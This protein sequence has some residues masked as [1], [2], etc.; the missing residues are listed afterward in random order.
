MFPRSL[1]EIVN[2]LMQEVFIS[3][4]GENCSQNYKA[5]Q[6]WF[7][8]RPDCRADALVKMGFG[9]YRER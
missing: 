2:E 3:V 7:S 9:F 8:D 1:R 4:K 5:S 6:D